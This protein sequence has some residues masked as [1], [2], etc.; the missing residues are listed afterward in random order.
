MEGSDSGE[1][2]A[3]LRSV[4]SWVL[5]FGIGCLHVGQVLDNGSLGASAVRPTITAADMDDTEARG[6]ARSLSDTRSADGASR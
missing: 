2:P 6:I 4:S 5:V 3:C 1:E